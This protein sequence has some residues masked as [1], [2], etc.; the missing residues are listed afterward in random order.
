MFWPLF[1]K[2]SYYLRQ[3]IGEIEMIIAFY[4]A[5]KA[6]APPVFDFCPKQNK[7]QKIWRK[8]Q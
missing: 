8:N 4:I 2:Q 7:N 1:Q 3:T 5:E 6:R